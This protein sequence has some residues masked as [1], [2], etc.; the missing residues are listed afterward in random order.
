L[1][2]AARRAGQSLVETALALALLCVAFFGFLQVARLSAAQ[3]VVTWA[4]AAAARARQ[5]G[6]NDFMV[7]KVIRVAAIPNAGRMLTP[8]PPATSG[9]ARWGAARPGALWDAALRGGG[10][11]P[12]FAVEQSRIPLY[13]GAARQGELNAILDY[14]DWET[15]RGD[16]RRRGADE[17]SVRVTQDFPL[18]YPLHRAFYAADDVR[19]NAAAAEDDYE[20]RRELHYPLY[21]Q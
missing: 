17:L 7:R 20:I 14:E 5:V 12:Q 18:K 9:A 1:T 11:S 13:L 19:I 21:L 2:F 4:A 16:W 8:T 3:A 6:L 15:V 10:V